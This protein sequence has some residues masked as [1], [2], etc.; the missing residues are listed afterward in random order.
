MHQTNFFKKEQG[1]IKTIVFI[2]PR[3]LFDDQKKTKKNLM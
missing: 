1:Y 2:L 3:A